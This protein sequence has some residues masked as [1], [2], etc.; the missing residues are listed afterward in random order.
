MVETLLLNFLFL[1]LPILTSVLFFETKLNIFNK[2]KLLIG[3]SISLLLCMTFPLKLDMGFIFDLRW[4][5]LIVMALFGGYKMVFPLYI[6]LN[7]YRLLIGGGE[8]FYHSFAFSTVILLVIP[9]FREKFIV[10]NPNRRVAYGILATL[11]MMVLY[12][13][14]L[15][16]F[17]QELTAEFW[18]LVVN[19]LLIYTP[20]IFIILTMIEKII[21]N[22]ERH[23]IYIQSERLKVISEL[24]ASIAHE[25]RNPLTVTNGFLQLLANSKTITEEENRYV[26]FSLKE[27]QRAEAIVNEFLSF[28]KPQSVHMIDSDFKDEI[29]YVVNI[30]HPYAA[31]NKVSI[32]VE[33]TNTLKKNYDENQ[34]RQ[35]FIN[36]IKN[37]IEAMKEDGGIV[38]IDVSAQKGNIQFVVKDSGKGMTSEE[39]SQLGIPYYS[40]KKEGTGL[41]MFMVYRTI[42]CLNG[43]IEVKSTP[44][45]GTTMFITIPV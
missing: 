29:E 45:K 18:K 4:I 5:P 20:V 11:L 7:S 43:K 12:F 14:S 26:D 37:S 9:F 39:I 36:L 25:I 17:Y 32:Q 35:C 15:S 33:F 21:S 28:S 40:T 19:A 31:K 44:G 6:I 41:G 23:D 1:L 34:I 38:S 30:L 3:S 2:Y 10:Q 42:D 27:L 13:T 24:S 8:G 16:Y 22:V